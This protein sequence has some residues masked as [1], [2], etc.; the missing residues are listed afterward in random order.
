MKP[1]LK[2]ECFMIINILTEMLSSIRVNVSANDPIYNTQICT[3]MTGMTGHHEGMIFESI[4]LFRYDISTDSYVIS[5]MVDKHNYLGTTQTMTTFCHMCRVYIINVFEQ[6]IIRLIRRKQTEMSF[7]FNVPVSVIRRIMPIFLTTHILNSLTQV[8]NNPN[9]GQEIEYKRTLNDNIP[10]VKGKLIMSGSLVLD[11]V[12][13][14]VIV[15]IYTELWMKCHAS[16]N[17]RHDIHESEHIG[18]VV[19]IKIHTRHTRAKP[20]PPSDIIQDHSN[21][22]GTRWHTNYRNG[23]GLLAGIIFERMH[24]NI[25]GFRITLDFITNVEENPEIFYLPDTIDKLIRS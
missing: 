21:W 8:L 22:Y 15:N 24:Q 6:S 23:L 12:N 9:V 10:H 14:D 3:T 20:Y 19:D 4:L 13:N 18:S 2:T 17:C 5:T 7:S 11:P 16:I 25:S 1:E